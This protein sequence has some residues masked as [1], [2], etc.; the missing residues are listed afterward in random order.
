MS[1]FKVRRSQV[2]GVIEIPA[3]KSHTLRAILFA[4]LGRGK[5]IIRNY[6]LSNDANRMIDACRLL[7][8]N[9]LMFADRLEVFGL[10]GQ[11]A[12]AEDVIDAGNSGI[13]LRFISAIAALSS[14]YIIVTG[15]YSIR[16]QRPIAPLL[17]ALRDLGATAISTKEDNYAPVIIHG[18]IQAVS[19]HIAGE[20]SQ[21]VSAL[22]IAASFVEGVTEINVTN[23]GEKPWILLTLHWL[24]RLGIRYENHEFLR[25]RIFGKCSYEGF[26]YTV[27]S[28]FSS[29]AFPIA[30][31]L[32]TNSEVTLTNIDM[33]DPQGDKELIYIL[34]K[35][36]AQIEID[37]A[38]K[39]L[40][41]NKSGKLVGM[42]IDI[43]TFIDA[44]P[45][46]AV[47]GCYA[48]AEMHIMNAGI[49]REKECDRLSAITL[50]LKKMGA[51][52][53]ELADGLIIK[54]SK[55]TAARLHSHHDHRIAMALLVACLGAEGESL[56]EDSECVAK[57]FP[58]V[59]QVFRSLGADVEV[60]V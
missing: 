21:P 27:P 4:A 37:A 11:I 30:A 28:D 46:L 1:R 12:L 40:K 14:H 54:P 57:T 49:A 55:L 29:A 41:V 52:I 38:Q 56:I 22:L 2:S 58:N 60:E 7:G 31:A 19:A 26:D 3:S 44:L 47:I 13:V 53:E 25:Y 45:I 15:D 24:D 33:D 59:A 50:E 39:T 32:I 9:I 42:P 20:D 48:T 8:A 18:P 5:S 23:P 17:K 34:Q 6:L 16:H 36:G 43:N 10:D 51:D 35:M